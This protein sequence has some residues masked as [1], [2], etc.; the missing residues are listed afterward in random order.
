MKK[1]VQIGF[2]AKRTED[3]GFVDDRPIF[4][5][6]PESAVGASGMTKCEE[7][8]LSRAA[9]N[10]FA[11]MAKENPDFASLFKN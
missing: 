10:V 6:I 1:R 4:R 5:D 2:V 7:R 9:E 11:E 8:C 3:G